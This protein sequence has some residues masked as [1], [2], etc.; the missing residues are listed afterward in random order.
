MLIPF[1]IWLARCELC[2]KRLKASDRME[3]KVGNRQLFIGHASCFS[4]LPEQAQKGF[5]EEWRALA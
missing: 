4:R 5:F 3:I 2:G 1:L